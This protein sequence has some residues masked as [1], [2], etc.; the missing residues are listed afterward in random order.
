MEIKTKFNVLDEVFFKTDTHYRS[1]K[2][3]E[4]LLKQTQDV[5]RISYM[6]EIVTKHFGGGHPP[7]VEQKEFIESN[8]F[9]K[10]SKIIEAHILKKEEALEAIQ[11]QI[12]VLQEEFN[13]L[14]L[15]EQKL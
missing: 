14:V 2:V 5:F 3:K 12:D 1:G 8:L 4:V 10:R 15:E 9:E 13:R 6:V 7:A 11:K